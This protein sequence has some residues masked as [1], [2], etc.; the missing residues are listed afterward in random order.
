MKRLVLILALCALG[1]AS[2]GASCGGPPVAE[3]CA[4]LKTAADQAC[5]ADVTSQGCVAAGLAYAAA[6]CGAYVAP[7]C[8][9]LPDGKVKC[10]ADTTCD[11]VYCGKDTGYV[12]EAAPACPKCPETCPE[13]QWCVDP[14]VGCVTKPVEPPPTCP[15]CPVGYSCKDP[16]VGCVKDPEVPPPGTVCDIPDADDPGWGQP[17]PPDK[18]PA[19]MYQK[20]KAAI[21]K[22]GNR[23]GYATPDESK[24][25]ETLR[26]IA[27]E[28][29]KMGVCAEQS[30][31]S[32][33]IK[34]PD[35]MYEEWHAVYFGNGCIIDGPNA[36]KGAWPYFGNGGGGTPPPSTGYQCPSPVPPRLWTAETLPGGWGEDQIGKPRFEIKAKMH[37]AVTDSTPIV[38][39]HACE[40]CASIGMG[41]LGPGVPRCGCPVR[42]DGHPDRVECENVLLVPPSGK[43]GP[44]WVKKGSKVALVGCDLAPETEPCVTDNPFQARPRGFEL[45]AC[46]WDDAVCSVVVAP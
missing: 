30:A 26:L 21:E 18:R 2:M 9:A 6:G 11:C 38:S 28:L 10:N 15:T 4:L 41:E 27:A 29:Q 45:Q 25:M 42:P 19:L 34:A 33:S 46:S 32:V 3:R 44:K 14:K 17:M 31:D 35:N 13:G 37:G 8:P 43:Y 5:S 12:W 36:Y 20:Y 22:V 40:Y 16:K 23:C 39:P 1:V 7:K 24:Q